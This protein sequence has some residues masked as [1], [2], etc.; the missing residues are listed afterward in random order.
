MCKMGLRLIAIG[1]GI[2][3]GLAAPGFV[4][5]DLAAN[6][7]KIAGVQGLA[8][9]GVQQVDGVIYKKRIWNPACQCWCT[10]DALGQVRCKHKSP[11]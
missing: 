11:K 1:I 5:A 10:E 8:G 3:A 9:S 7:S 4:Q 2:V 6:H